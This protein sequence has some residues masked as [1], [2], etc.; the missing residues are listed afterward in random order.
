VGLEVVQRSRAG[1]MLIF[2]LLFFLEAWQA[3]GWGDMHV[4]NTQAFYSGELEAPV[5]ISGY[6]RDS[7][8]QAYLQIDPC[9]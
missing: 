5:H 9:T 7:D 2:V 4:W 3:P 6:D 8:I 1:A